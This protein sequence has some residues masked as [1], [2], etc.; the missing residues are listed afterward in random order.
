MSWESA[1]A[2]GHGSDPRQA[3]WF[4]ELF[5]IARDVRT[6]GTFTDASEWV[7]L[8][9]VESGLFWGHLASAR[10]LGIPLVATKRTQT[11][12]V[13][14]EASVAVQAASTAWASFLRRK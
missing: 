10:S 4:A 8:D 6:L 13:A 5:S 14:A 12:R 7:T 3:R 9:D 1:A 2:P 11:V